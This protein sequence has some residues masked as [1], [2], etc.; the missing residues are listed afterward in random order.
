MLYQVITIGSALV[1]VFVHTDK[2]ELMDTP[3]GVHL[4]QL[5]GSK[6]DVE[7]FNVYTGGGGSNT[8]VGFS[9]LGLKTSVICETGRDNFSYLVLK[10]LKDN[11]VDTNLVISEKMEK[12]GGSVILTCEKGER[13]VLVH[14][15]ASAKLDP[16]DISAYW[17]SQ[18]ELVHLSSIGGN[19]KTLEKIFLSIKRSDS[20]K[21]SW[22]PGKAELLMLADERLIVSDIPCEV[23]LVNNEEWQMIVDVQNQILNNFPYVVVTAGKNGGDVY[24]QAEQLFHF[25]ALS[26]GVV[27][28]TGAGDSF[29]VGFVAG[30]Y[31]G[32][33][34]QEA[35]VLGAKNAASV[36]N[37]YGAKT[38]L[39]AKE[40]ILEEI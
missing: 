13:S 7:D 40:K 23:F 2:F 16:Y 28:S 12:T 30:L 20:T 39:L 27:D 26:S 3:K 38:G 4:C 1:D 11:G 33:T 36:V 31:W 34:P 6:T 29:S 35:A 5:H 17:L 19:Q 18:T 21:L 22:N 14:R 37:N 10:D 15:G 9:R 8:A 24:Y 32:K 25:P